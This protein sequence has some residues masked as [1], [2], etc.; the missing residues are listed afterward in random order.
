MEVI[1]IL[2]SPKVEKKQLYTAKYHLERKMNYK[3]SKKY[4]DNYSVISKNFTL[5]QH[6]DEHDIFAVRLYSLEMKNKIEI[7]DNE[8][9]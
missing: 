3:L 6:F 8:N 9:I 2:Y 5:I 1:H 7:P 4:S